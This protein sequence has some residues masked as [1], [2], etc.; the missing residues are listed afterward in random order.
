GW[1]HPLWHQYR[2]ALRLANGRLDAA[3]A[4]AEAGARAADQIGAP[5]LSAP[6]LAVSARVAAR[7]GDLESAQ[8]YLTR[9]LAIGSAVYAEEVAGAAAIIQD[10]AGQPQAAAQPLR[11]M[12]AALPARML[13]IADEPWFGP[14]AV[15]IALRAGATELA[16]QAAMASCRLA[17]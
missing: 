14:Q 8:R 10:C 11:P 2:A 17:E 15:R 4:D 3:A 1:S 13:V 7:R 12:L 9:A 16:E 5:A 6:L